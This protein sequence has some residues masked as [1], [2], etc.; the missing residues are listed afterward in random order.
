MEAGNAIRVFVRGAPFPVLIATA[1]A[2]PAVITFLVVFAIRAP[3]ILNESQI[4]KT[5][6]S[7][8]DSKP[9][10]VDNQQKSDSKAEPTQKSD[11]SDIVE[12]L[13]PRKTDEERYI[14][15]LS[16]LAREYD[17]ERSAILAAEKARAEALKKE[18]ELK[19][20]CVA[21]A[22]AIERGDAKA[23][24]SFVNDGCAVFDRL[25]PAQMFEGNST[26]KERNEFTGIQNEKT[27][28]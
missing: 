1:V 2:I 15:Y 23:A 9:S 22:N 14:E 3:T 8:P 25:T 27:T 11:R 6:P 16:E 7:M 24:T 5:V 4:S 28:R 17:T 21:H 20:K 18:T 10:E 12:A 19:L 26:S 13:Y